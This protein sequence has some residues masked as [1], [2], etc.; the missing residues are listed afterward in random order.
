M[1]FLRR[2]V[3]FRQT[4]S[5]LARKSQKRVFRAS[6]TEHVPGTGFNHIALISMWEW[7]AALIKP[8]INSLEEV[9]YVT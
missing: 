7:D 4:N 8:H 9:A 1:Q 5:C 6:C 3:V 2:D